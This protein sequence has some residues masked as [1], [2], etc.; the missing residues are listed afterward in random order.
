ME[1]Q[2]QTG[3]HNSV[4]IT[5]GKKEFFIMKSDYSI[6]VLC[7]NAAHAAYNGMGKFFDTWEQA[8]DAYK[9]EAAKESIKTAR[10]ILK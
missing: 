2:I 3:T 5:A 8:I 7:K 10:E 4:T 6:N 9:S 1:L